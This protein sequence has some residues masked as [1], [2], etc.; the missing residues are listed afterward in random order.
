MSEPHGLAPGDH[1]RGSKGDGRMGAR[2]PPPIFRQPQKMTTYHLSMVIDWLIIFG[3][4]NS[5]LCPHSATP[6]SNNLGSTPGPG[7]CTLET[8]SPQFKAKH[9]KSGP[10]LD[11]FILQLNLCMSHF[12]CH[13]KTISLLLVSNFHC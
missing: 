12:T 2:P 11:T 3:A 13:L 5:G 4:C 7:C 9:T 10:V 6:L 8:K 1:R